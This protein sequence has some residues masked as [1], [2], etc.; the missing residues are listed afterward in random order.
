MQPCWHPDGQQIAWIAWNH[1]QMPWDGTTLNLAKVTESSPGL[2]ELGEI[3][4]ITG[5]ENTAVFGAQFSPDG[6]YLAYVSDPDG[7]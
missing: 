4:P 3:V 5:G 1:P 6:R 2:L 7:W